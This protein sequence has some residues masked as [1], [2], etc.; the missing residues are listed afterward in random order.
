MLSLKHAESKSESCFAEVQ[1]LLE[2]L[3][4]LWSMTSEFTHH[5]PDWMDG[6]IIAINA[7]QVAS[8]CETWYRQTAKIGKAL[9]GPAAEVLATLRGKLEGFQE[10]LTLIKALRN[11]GLRDRHW[12]KISQSG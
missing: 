8:D 2:P 10:H 3:S 12:D 11:P 5:L 1:K 4:G 9:A 6:P 7:E